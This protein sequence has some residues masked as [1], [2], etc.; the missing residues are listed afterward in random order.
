MLFLQSWLEDYICLQNYSTEQL[1]DL[2]TRRSSEVEEI[3]VIQ[4]YF[5][6]KVLVGQITNVR[7]HPNADRLQVFDLDLGSRG[8]IQI[9][10]AAPNVRDG[11]LVP[12]AVEGCKLPFLTVTKRQM[13]GEVSAGM[14]LGK[15]ELL[16]E[17]EP[18][19]GLWELNE[20]LVNRAL[21]EVLGQSICEVLPEYF[22]EEVVLDIKVLPDKIGTIGNHLG[23]AIELAIVLGD[24]GL[25]TES[26]K[27]F[28]DPELTFAQKLDKLVTGTSDLQVRLQDEIG[29][30]EHFWLFELEINKTIPDTHYYLPHTLL[31]RLFLLEK[32]LV[33]GLVDLSNYLLADVGQPSHFFG[34]SKLVTDSLNQHWQLTKLNESQAWV[35]L[36][37]LKD[38]ILPRNTVVLQNKQTILAIPGIAGGESTKAEPQDT[39][40]VV[41][42]ANFPAEA[43][44][45]NAFLLKYRSDGA[46][47]WAGGVRPSQMLVWL[48]RLW[49]I[50]SA[51]EFVTF[52]LKSILHWRNDQDQLTL[53]EAIAKIS[54][55]AVTQMTLNLE[56]LASKFDNRGLVYWQPILESKLSLLGNFNIATQ[57]FRPWPNYLELSDKYAV[58]LE[59]AKLVG[60]ENFQEHHLVTNI[61]NVQSPNFLASSRLVRLV[62]SFGF[63]EV[64]TRP[65]VSSTEVFAPQ[66]CLIV[67]KAYRAQENYLRDNLLFSL[68]KCLVDNLNRGEKDPRL[69]ELNKIYTKNPQS[70]GALKEQILL[71]GVTVT[72]DPYLLTSLLNYLLDGMDNAYTYQPLDQNEPL[73]RFGVGYLYLGQQGLQ[74]RLLQ[75]SNR[76]KKQV[77]LPLSKS[78]WY[79]ELD[80]TNWNQVVRTYPRYRDES[81][82]PPVFRELS[83]VVPKTFRL[84]QIYQLVT[85]LTQ[86]G[87]ETIVRPKERFS[88][89]TERDILNLQ[90][91]FVSFT[92]TLTSSEVDGWQTNFLAELGKLAPV[93]V[94]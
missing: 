48:I 44:A 20:L 54:Q 37:Q 84:R 43:V 36:G 7:P 52:Q 16:L 81:L 40:L 65:F 77:N 24:L 10:S 91:K 17:T 89:D 87:L 80:L 14:C 35:G 45:K 74:A 42:V 30:A 94:R 21:D 22:P 49:E 67:L 41:E 79:F 2:I 66:Q 15:S 90:L 11:L 34:W 73:S 39:R 85:N 18:S 33:G 3:R 8:K 5:A 75:L 25:L 86:T 6:G 72:D 50:L 19:S 61:Q 13:R 38:T 88:L 26:A 63:H 64:I 59:V 46:K 51:Q 78:L 60:F 71:A 58:L 53:T 70:L 27:R 28:L 55:T 56:F 32:N 29:Y 47:I 62:T 92:R 1:A 31:R 9:I 57:T 93:E 23:M 76:F 12:V 82:Y 68:V 83:L 4:D 69:F